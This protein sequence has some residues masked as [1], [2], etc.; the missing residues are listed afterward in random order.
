LCSV[1]GAC[2]ALLAIA[3]TSALA[4]SLL[5][6][7]GGPGEGSQ[8]ILGSSVVG[9]SGGGG[10]GGSGGGAARAGREGS[11]AAE[12]RAE[13]IYGPRT[14]EAPAGAVP[15]SGSAASGARSGPGGAGPSGAGSP[16]TSSGARGGRGAASVGSAGTAR[17]GARPGAGGANGSGGAVGSRGGLGSASEL[18]RFGGGSRTVGLTGADLLY[19][20]LAAAALVSTGLIT[21]RLTHPTANNGRIS[22]KGRGRTPD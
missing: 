4:N 1:L 10:A 18:V 12:A 15:G 8:A 19:M 5:S 13:E 17:G 16:A 7:Y 2:G 9:R 21:R 11:S 6:G 3:P 22:L 14:I 20:L